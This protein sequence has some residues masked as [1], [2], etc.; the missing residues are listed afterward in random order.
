M[1]SM[2]AECEHHYQCLKASSNIIT[3]KWAQMLARRLHTEKTRD[4]NVQKSQEYIPERMEVWEGWRW[5]PPPPGCFFWERERERGNCQNFYNI[6]LFFLV[7][8]KG[9]ASPLQAGWWKK[10]GSMSCIYFSKLLPLINIMSSASR[11][12]C[13]TPSIMLGIMHIKMF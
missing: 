3:S 8:S 10:P 5:I 13:Q 1:W 6:F 7:L 9:I 11:L 4:G 12:G 2:E